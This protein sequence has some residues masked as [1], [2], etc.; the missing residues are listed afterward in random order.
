MVAPMLHFPGSSWFYINRQHEGRF[1][2]YL[3]LGALF[4]PPPSHWGNFFAPWGGELA[5]AGSQK[6]G[7]KGGKLGR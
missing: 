4:E 3:S 6:E 5:A 2:E 1:G 7:K